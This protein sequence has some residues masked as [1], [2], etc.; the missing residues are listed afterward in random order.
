M[1]IFFSPFLI[2]KKGRIVEYLFRDVVKYNLDT[3]LTSNFHGTNQL[4]PLPLWTEL[5]LVIRT[6]VNIWG[7]YR[8]QLFLQTQHNQN[9]QTYCSSS[10]VWIW[11]FFH[12][13]KKIWEIGEKRE[14]RSSKPQGMCCL[15]IGVCLSQI[16]YLGL[17]LKLD[18]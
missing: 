18:S 2:R 6:L 4:P 17:G 7:K 13:P 16:F 5:Y 11:Q 12:R 15:P 3:L 8:L 9:L 14:K 10:Y 1:L